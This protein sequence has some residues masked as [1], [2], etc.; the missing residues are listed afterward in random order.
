MYDNRAGDVRSPFERSKTCH[1]SPRWNVTRAHGWQGGGGLFIEG[2]AALTN[3]DVY[4]NQAGE[5][6]WSAYGWQTETDIPTDNH[7]GGLY[8]AGTATLTNTNVYENQAVRVCS[9][10]FT[11]L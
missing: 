7:G 8:V 2:T 6:A 4:A 9:P 5:R 10:L 1:P 3:T 11:F